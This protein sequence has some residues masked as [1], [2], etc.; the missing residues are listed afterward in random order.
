MNRKT[1]IYIV[2]GIVAVIALYALIPGDDGETAAMEATVNKGELIVHIT[3]SGELLAAKSENIYAPGQGMRTVNIWQVNI[4]DLIPEGTYVD[5]GDYIATLDRGEIGSKLKENEL[6]I[7]KANSVFTQ[8]QLDTT[9][10]MREARN[11]LTNLKFAMEEAQITLD[12]SKF[13]PPAT[14]RQNKIALERAEIKYQQAVKNYQVKKLQFAAKMQEAQA[15]LNQ[16]I[17]KQEKIEAVLE[18][19]VINAPKSGILIYAKSWNGNKKVVGSRI[20]AWDPTVALLPNLTQMIS[21]TYVNEVDIGKVSK[22]QSVEIELDGDPDKK[23]TGVVDYVATVG[24]QL[25]NSE[26]KVFEVKININETDSS[27]LPGMSTSNKILI[28]KH[29]DVLYLPIECIYSNDSVS[30]VYKKSGFGIE[31]QVVKIGANNVNF[32]IIQ[33][34]LNEGDRVL[35][36]APEEPDSYELIPIASEI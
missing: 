7:Q 1:I 4:T 23:L 33:A 9:L 8:T 3:S 18:D 34:G 17:K 13:E 28:A 19:F 27:L 15:T 6:E 32:T 5:S 36:S 29:Q 12:Q 35:F 2:I 10:S 24:E 16:A 26:A 25:P 11:E 20:S 21:Q 22:G 31:K 14:I 30:F